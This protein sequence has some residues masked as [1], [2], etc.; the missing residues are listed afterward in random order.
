MQVNVAFTVG[1]NFT[2]TGSVKSLN[3]SVY[4]VKTFFSSNVDAD[5]VN[6]GISV[7][8]DPLMITMNNKLRKGVSLPIP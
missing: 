1:E 8:Q 3:M 4:N 7:L 5:T 6:V 2:L